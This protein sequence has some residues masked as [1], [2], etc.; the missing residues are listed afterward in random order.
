MPSGMTPQKKWRDRLLCLRSEIQK[1]LGFSESDK[2]GVG[3]GKGR[4]QYAPT[5][6]P[7]PTVG[8]QCLRP[9]MRRKG[10][11]PANFERFSVGR[12]LQHRYRNRRGRMQYAPTPPSNPTVGAQCL[13]PQCLRPEIT[14]LPPSIKQRTT[15]CGRTNRPPHRCAAAHPHDAPPPLHPQ[16]PHHTRWYCNV[17]TCHWQYWSRYP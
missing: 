10:G 8:A 15:H 9:E 4:M 14:P 17:R 16:F 12:S 7:N 11:R 1:K 3:R 2:R 5:P 13:R 6:P